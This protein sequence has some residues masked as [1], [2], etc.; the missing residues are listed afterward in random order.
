[1]TI[2]EKCSYESTDWLSI[3]LVYSFDGH[4]LRDSTSMGLFTD[5]VYDPETGF[6]LSSTDHKGRA[7]SYVYDDWGNLVGTH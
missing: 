4:L 3:V 1:M 6:L 7:T 2:Q 5:Y